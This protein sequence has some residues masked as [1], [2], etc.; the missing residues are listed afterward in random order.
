MFINFTNHPHEIWSELQRQT[1]EQ[2]YGEI[3]D[4][5]FPPLQP[6]WEIEDLQKCVEEYTA[7]I[8]ALK[9][10]AVLV[11]GEFTLVFMLVDK[12]LQDGVKVV[13][14]CSKRM[15]V[16]KKLPDDSNEKVS[17]FVFEKFREYSYYKKR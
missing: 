3:M 4:L 9:P 15:T 7:K 1:A 12:L 5:P 2:Q 10:D 11:A 6:S 13:C 16:E 8:E 14:S 17:Q